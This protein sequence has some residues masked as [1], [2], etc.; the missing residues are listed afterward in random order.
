MSQ[1]FEKEHLGT[2]YSLIHFS[3]EPYRSKDVGIPNGEKCRGCY[4]VKP[5]NSIMHGTGITLGL[6]CMQRHIVFL[7]LGLISYHLIK[8][9]LIIRSGCNPQLKELDKIG[10]RSKFA[11]FLK[12]LKY[13]LGVSIA[14]RPRADEDQ[15]AN[16][17]RIRE[18]Q[19]LGDS[20]AHRDSSNSGTFDA[21]GLHQAGRVIRH[22][23]GRIWT[24][25][26]IRITC[27]SIIHQEASETLFVGS[28][29]IG[30]TTPWSSQ[31]HD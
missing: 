8:M 1:S 3:C 7:S 27:A 9:L 21:Q 14:P 12:V 22:H 11:H 30:P 2:G 26:F 23:F 19:L 5:V 4:L 20:T 28:R 10:R 6:K 13:R 31:T 25:R 16:L 29:M 15:T 24:A 17:F 18:R